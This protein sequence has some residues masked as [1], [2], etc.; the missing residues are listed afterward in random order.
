MIWDRYSGR[1]NIAIIGSDGNR[2]HKV[3]QAK[4]R[5]RMITDDDNDVMVMMK[6]I[7]L[8]PNFDNLFHSIDC[9]NVAY[10]IYV[11]PETNK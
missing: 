7:Q 3:L 2:T 9:N 1:L 4:H 8:T 5:N 11:D 6:G 10:V